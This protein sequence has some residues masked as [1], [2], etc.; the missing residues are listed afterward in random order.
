MKGK[1]KKRKGHWKVNERKTKKNK[2]QKLYK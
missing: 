1:Q 2:K